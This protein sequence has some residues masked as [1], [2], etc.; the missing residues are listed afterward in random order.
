MIARPRISPS[1]R[2]TGWPA[3]VWKLKYAPEYPWESYY[4]AH[5]FR[6]FSA[7]F[8]AQHY[9]NPA[10]NHDHGPLWVTGIRL[11]LEFG[12]KPLVAK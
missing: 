12:L 1:P 4:N 6:S 9:N 7:T 3:P 11:H 2:S 8:D 5:L 10:Y